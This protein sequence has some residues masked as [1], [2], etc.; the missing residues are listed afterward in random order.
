MKWE[1]IVI[2]ILTLALVVAVV[3]RLKPQSPATASNAGNPVDVSTTAQNTDP[4]QGPA[5]LV[6][7]QPPWAFAPPVANFLPPAVAPGGQPVQVSGSNS[8][9][10]DCL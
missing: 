3:L 2:V 5:Y 8:N 4:A 10:Y 9:C 1:R 6:Y 7:N